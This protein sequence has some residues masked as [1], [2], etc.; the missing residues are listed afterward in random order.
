MVFEYSLSLSKQRD[1]DPYR[2]WRRFQISTFHEKVHELNSF[3]GLVSSA[4]LLPEEL[5]RPYEKPLG[6]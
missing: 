3:D 5:T 2:K 4:S 1:D 6:N